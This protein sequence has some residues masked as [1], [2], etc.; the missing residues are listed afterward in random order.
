[1]QWWR[2]RRNGLTTATAAAPPSG[3]PACDTVQGGAAVPMGYKG[4]VKPDGTAIETP[5]RL[6]CPDGRTYL[7]TPKAVGMP[8]GSWT[9]V[10]A[11]ATVQQAEAAACAP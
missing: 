2:R 9:A 11:G 1:V 10:P 5:Q 7:R 3:P 8:G 6:T 4:C